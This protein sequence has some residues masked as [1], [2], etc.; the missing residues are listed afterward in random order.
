MAFGAMVGAWLH[1]SPLATRHLADVAEH[2]HHPDHP[3]P[4]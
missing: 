3:A 2:H 1:A 4:V